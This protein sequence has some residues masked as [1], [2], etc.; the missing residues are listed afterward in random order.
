MTETHF[1]SLSSFRKLKT[2]LFVCKTLGLPLLDNSVKP[3][4][5]TAQ[6]TE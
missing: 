3:V 4:T 1:K 5:Q 6:Q 2:F